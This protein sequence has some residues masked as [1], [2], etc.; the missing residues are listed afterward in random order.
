MLSMRDCLDYCDLTEDEIELIAEHEQIPD[1]AAAQL[2]CGLVQTPEGVLIIT[3]Y[4]QDLVDRAARCGDVQKA[5]RANRLCEQ[6][7][8]DHPI[9]H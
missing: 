6:F 3:R 8:A 2:V 1:V 4:M 5:Q 7:M 9:R